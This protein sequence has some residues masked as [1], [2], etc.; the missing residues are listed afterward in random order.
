MPITGEIYSNDGKLA[1]V[2]DFITTNL[3]AILVN[4]SSGVMTPDSTVADII[5]TEG[6]EITNAGGYS[7]IQVTK[8]NSNWVGN[9]YVWSS[10]PVTFTASGAAMDDFTHMVF[11]SGASGTIGDTT[12]KVQ[13]IAEVIDGI[14][15]LNDGDSYTHTLTFTVDATII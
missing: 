2:E 12:G 10:N 11:I 15:T 5:T 7:R 3:Y 14:Q 4:D 6:L 13:R 9:K 1:I 8:K